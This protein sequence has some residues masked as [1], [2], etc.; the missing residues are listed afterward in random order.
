MRYGLIK[1]PQKIGVNQEFLEWLTDPVQN[2]GG[3]EVDFGCYGVNLLT[4]FMDATSQ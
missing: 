1:G 2:G 3:A 4:W